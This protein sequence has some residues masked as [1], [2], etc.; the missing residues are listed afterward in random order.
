VHFHGGFRQ[1]N[2]D[3]QNAQAIPTS[4]PG[5]DLVDV[6]NPAAL[7]RHCAPKWIGWIGRTR[8]QKEMTGI[9]EAARAA[10][11]DILAT[12]YHSC[13]RE[14]CHAEAKYP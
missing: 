10:G 5:L 6:A 9:L 12:L 7:G 11:V 1:S 13:H 4:I 2:L 14:I 3:W 8:R